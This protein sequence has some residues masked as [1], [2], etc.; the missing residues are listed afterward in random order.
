MLANFHTLKQSRGVLLSPCRDRIWLILSSVSKRGVSTSRTS[1]IFEESSKLITRKK[2][3]VRRSRETLSVLCVPINR[4]SGCIANPAIMRLETHSIISFNS[5][6][7]RNVI[8]SS[9][10]VFPWRK[11]SANIPSC[12]LPHNS[13]L[14]DEA[15][16]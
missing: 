4:K 1:S 10:S 5:A 6:P 7:G 14:D 9:S 15:L 2:E 8:P 16:Q 11:A 12:L 13:S 3:V